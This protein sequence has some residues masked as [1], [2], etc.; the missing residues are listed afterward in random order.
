MG[1]YLG[2]LFTLVHSC[3][4]VVLNNCS[5]KSQSEM[6]DRL[7]GSFLPLG[8]FFLVDLS[9]VHSTSLVSY[10]IVTHQFV[11]KSS[12]EQFEVDKRTMHLS[13]PRDEKVTL[14]ELNYL[15]GDLASPLFSVVLKRIVYNSLTLL[16]TLL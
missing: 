11:F 13:H 1:L 6:L 4:V 16:L 2:L 9:Y 3:L 8:L 12:T 15:A 7:S 10:P 14:G 5:S